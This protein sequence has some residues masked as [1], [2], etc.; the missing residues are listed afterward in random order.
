MIARRIGVSVRTC[1]SHIARIYQ[2]F[3]ARSR[4]QL[5]VLVA[6]RGLL[7]PAQDAAAHSGA[8]TSDASLGCIHEQSPAV[9]SPRPG[10]PRSRARLPAP[11]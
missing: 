11:R 7:C 6:G 4:F 1:R 9:G 10:A 5:G 3:G 8:S 2:E